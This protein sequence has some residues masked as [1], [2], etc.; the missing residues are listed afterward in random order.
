MREVVIFCNAYTQIEIALYVATHNWH[1]CLITIV[2]LGHP[3]L[4]KFFKVINE[5]LF[6]NT[7]D[8]IYFEGYQPRR[9]KAKGVK[10]ALYLLPDIRKEKQYLKGFFDEHFAGLKGAEVYFSGKGFGTY[11]FYFM[12]KLSKTNRLVYVHC[13]GEELTIEEFTPTNLIDLAD[14]VINKLIYGFGIA[15]GRLPH[16]QFPCIP[17]KFLKKEVAETI[18]HE[19][20]NEMMKDFDLSRFKEI[21]DIGNNY[22]VIYFDQY[23]VEVGYVTDRDTYRREL[24]EIF[25]VVSKYFP[26]NEIAHKYHPD[27]DGDETGIKIGNVIER[28]MPAEFLY[29]DNVKMYLS[30]TSCS[31]AN[32]EKGL[33][34]SL[35]DLIT[36]RDN[37]TRNQLKELLMRMSHSEILFP[38]S[39]DEFEKLLIGIKEQRF[40]GGW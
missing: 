17:D 24:T 2:M 21:F 23:L 6:H 11:A 33:A 13:Q 14:L 1:D 36:F 25:N 26:K 12:K 7:I 4:F 8:I 3:N 10:K 38:K 15:M 22:R 20:R 31:I 30:I 19:A 9:A 5:R 16:I 29:N 39:L 34:V 32:V 37:E 40:V 27:Y 18:D 28:F 35:A